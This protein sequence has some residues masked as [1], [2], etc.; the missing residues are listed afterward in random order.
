MGTL[1]TDFRPYLRH[2]LGDQAGAGSDHVP[3]YEDVAL[4]QGIRYVVR[5]GQVDGYA[6]GQ[7]GVS[8]EPTVV[9]PNHY[10][11]IVLRAAL[12]FVT[13]LPDREGVRTRAISFH[14]AT[15]ATRIM[16]TFMDN[17][18]ALED[19]EYFQSWGQ[20]EQTWSD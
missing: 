8:V 18:A 14:R 19:G 7:D 2:A 10:A 20:F 15:G 11:L 12:S 13:P 16:Q 17:I 9:D 6:L 5:L 1:V 3:R 4:D